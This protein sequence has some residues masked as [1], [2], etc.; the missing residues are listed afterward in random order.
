MTE[1]ESP[2]R[3][4]SLPVRDFQ[5]KEEDSNVIYDYSGTYTRDLPQG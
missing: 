4:R 3:P 1:G 5:K 2:G